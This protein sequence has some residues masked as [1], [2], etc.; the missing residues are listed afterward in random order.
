M[1]LFK[2]TAL[3][4]GTLL[5][6]PFVQANDTLGAWGGV[7]DWPIIPIHTVLNPD[8]SLMT[9]GTNN[10]G[11]QGAE[12]HYSV[13]NPALGT[14]ANAHTLLPNETPTDIFCAAQVLL[15]QTGQVLLAGGD[16]GTG[17]NW[18]NPNTT[19]Y[20][21][22]TSTLTDAGFSMAYPR[23]YPTTTTLPNGEIL[24]QG[25]S[26]D[27][28][29]GNGMLTPEI[30]NPATGWR[31][32]FGA[33]SAYAYGDDFF[34]WWYPRAWVLPNGRVFGIAGPAMFYLDYQG[35]GHIEEAGAFPGNNI[36]A[37]STAV[38]Y[39]PGKILQVGGGHYVNGGGPLASSAA[40][41]IDVTGDNPVVTQ[42]QPMHFPRHWANS[43]ILPNGQVLVTGGSDENAGLGG[44]GPSLAAE[45]W[46]PATG[47]W[48]VLASEVHARLYHSSAIL[49]P[50]ATIVSGGGGA[51]GPVNNL[52][53]QIF[54]PP[55]LYVGTQLAARPVVSSS[56]AA[57]SYGGS[58]ELT[59]NSSKPIA[60]MTFLKTGAVTH[61][62]NNDQRFVELNF[63][64]AGNTLTAQIPASANIATPGYYLVYALDAAG[65]PSIGHMVHLAP[66]S[67]SFAGNLVQD[68]GFETLV[69]EDGYW[70]NVPAGQN[71]GQWQVTQ[72]T[73]SVHDNDHNGLGLGGASG[74]R[75]IDLNGPP[76]GTISQT[77]NGLTPGQEYVLT[78]DYAIHN[79]AGGSANAQVSIADLDDTWTATNSGIDN[80]IQASYT[81]TATAA[82]ETLSFAGS[83]GN[84]CCGVLLDDVAIVAGE[85][86]AVTP[87]VSA[88]PLEAGGLQLNG[89]NYGEI[90]HT[91]AMNLTQSF[92]LSARIYANS[93]ANWNGII[94]KGINNSPYALQVWG[95]GALRLATNWDIPAANAN[96]TA[97]GTWNSSLT[98]TTGE[99]HHVA[100]VSDG[101]TLKF[102]IDGELDPYQPA[103]TLSLG[104]NTEPM[105]IGADLPGGDEYFDGAIADVAVFNR[106]LSDQQ[107][108]N[109]AQGSSQLVADVSAPE[110]HTYNGTSDAIYIPHGANHNIQNE[111]T[112]SARVT[113]DAF[114]N[115]DGVITKGINTSPYALHLWGNGAIRF[116]ANWGGPAGAIGGGSWNS[117]TT[118]TAGTTHDIA[119][120]YDGYT[121]KFYIDGVLDSY[122]PAATIQFGQTTEDLVLGSDLPGGD[123][124]FDGSIERVKV[125]SRAL[126]LQEVQQLRF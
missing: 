21:S 86:Q 126:S 47:E 1:T 10:T 15:P 73:I 101:H 65:V 50:D 115:W 51:P 68:G 102:Y 93:F 75:H 64:Q 118:L 90:A 96:T 54:T 41:L 87:V 123:E 4:L 49:L 20:S 88:Y 37:T 2:K 45:L 78:F 66:E 44:A 83:G 7:F 39:Q 92:T 71:L 62:F 58:I 31:S 28:V 117:S 61:S 40:T 114:D 99:W 89:N 3:S 124:Y 63:A 100:V 12:L 122:Q 82:T 56:Q 24:V 85:N 79:F 76:L 81:F 22:N 36:G 19:I 25:G 11:G 13:W 98:M 94:T 46:N 48:T 59:V 125:F 70:L 91:D 57:V 121:I 113:V 80:W 72:G 108:Q 38:M 95:D 14:G 103:V 104:Q 112:L 32:L 42:A 119:V 35:E 43:T 67:D 9:F 77:I 60:R 55:Y 120:T 74:L 34:R 53:A 16:N 111:I 105:I 109:L 6:V 27:G 97:V 84:P 110:V 23:W 30:Y 26:D 69:P 18:G 5:C 8:G 106:Q 33:S 29:V 107:I 52:N 116:T 17:G